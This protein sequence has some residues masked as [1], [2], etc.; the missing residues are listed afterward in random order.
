VLAGRGWGKTRVLSEAVIAEAKA[1]PGA[2]IALVGRTAADVRDVIVGGRL[3]GILAVSPPD[4]MPRHIQSKRRIDWPN[5]AVAYTYSAEE[6]AQLRGPQHTFA[7]CDELAAWHDED[8]WH[9]LQF[10]LR[11]G[12]NPRC[13]I[14]T[15]PRPTAIVRAILED[16]RT[17]ATRG[18]TLDNAENLSD[19]FIADIHKAYDGTRMG[20]QE[21]EGE[22]LSDNPGALWSHDLI[23]SHRV[24]EAPDL[25]RIVVAVDPAVTSAETSDHTGIVVAGITDSEHI[26]VLADLSVKASPDGW[27]RVAV[28]ALREFGAD[29]VV[30]EVN[31]GG[32][33]VQSTLRAIDR[34]V[35]YRAV[36]A[37]RG[38]VARAEPISAL[39]ERGRVHHVGGLAKLEDEMCGWS[40]AS[41]GSGSPDRMDALV[42]ACTDLA[43]GPRG[44]VVDQDY[45]RFNVM[46]PRRR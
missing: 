10:G 5:G 33:L 14:A 44:A 36:R 11:V 13:V 25:R 37:S 45:E 30:A 32:D 8:A 12:D 41:A 15:T 18:K 28:A 17:F 26:Y 40:P 9:Q 29:R 16:P 1:D 39:Y 46:L 3:S 24:A 23:D 2:T 43:F 20:R 34:H 38:K 4:F 7:A 21:L 6:P 31:Q 19:D 42:W 22:I 27:A 35:P